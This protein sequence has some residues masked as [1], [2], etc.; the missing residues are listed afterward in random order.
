MG[1]YINIISRM[2][3]SSKCITKVQS[4]LIIK[5]L[6]SIDG[7][8]DAYWLTESSQKRI[9]IGTVKKYCNIS[10]QFIASFL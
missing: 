7:F 5:E 8:E 3:E 1:H 6:E 2:G 10:E 4:R 9:F